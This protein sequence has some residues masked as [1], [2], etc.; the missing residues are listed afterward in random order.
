MSSTAIYFF[1]SVSVEIKV[2]FPS[3][4]GTEFIDIAKQFKK[5]FIIEVAAC[6]LFNTCI[7]NN[8]E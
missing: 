2:Q 4:V 5:Q 6:L 1:Y 8:S 3:Y 7:I